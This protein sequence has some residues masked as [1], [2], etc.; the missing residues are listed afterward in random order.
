MRFD[1]RLNVCIHHTTGRQTDN[2]CENRLYRVYKHSTGCGF[3]NRLYHVYSR[4]YNPV[5]QPVERTVTDGSTRLSYQLSNRIDNRLYRVNGVLKLI[6]NMLITFKLSVL[7]SITFIFGRTFAQVLAVAE[8][9]DSFTTIDIGRKL[10]GAMPLFRRS[11]IP[12]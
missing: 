9:G 11:W 6:Y 12:I 4:L 2:R 7:F 3:D 1:K 8:V 5:W 10:G